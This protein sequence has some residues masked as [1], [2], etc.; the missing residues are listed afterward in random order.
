MSRVYPSTRRASRLLVCTPAPPRPAWPWDD[1]G[2]GVCTPSSVAADLA[3]LRHQYAD[4][5]RA[6]RD[7]VRTC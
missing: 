4:T 2:R 5:L 7:V 1:R 6:M 3:W